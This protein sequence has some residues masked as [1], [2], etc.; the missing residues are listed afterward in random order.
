[1]QIMGESSNN[2]RRFVLLV[3]TTCDDDKLIRYLKEYGGSGI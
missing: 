1:M 3:K 2:K